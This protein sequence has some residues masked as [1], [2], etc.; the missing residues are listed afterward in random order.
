MS[1]P[2]DACRSRG[3]TNKRSEGTFVGDLC[4]PCALRT[5]FAETVEKHHPRVAVF[6]NGW[7][8]GLL[9]RYA[10]KPGTS[11]LD[12]VW[13]VE[14]LEPY[15]VRRFTT[16]ELDDAQGQGPLIYR[17]T[18]YTLRRFADTYGPDA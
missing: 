7:R 17:G 18:R 10:W 9:K 12:D 1:K 13:T 5:R 16:R 11:A 3:C 14:L 4:A 15:G 8:S 6:D 2:K